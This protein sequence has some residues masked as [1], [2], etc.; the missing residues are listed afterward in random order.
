LQT[1]R[2]RSLIV[3]SALLGALASGAA[4]SNAQTINPRI[5]ELKY[6]N[7]FPTRETVDKLYNEMDF[8]NAVMAYRYATPLVAYNEFDVGLKQIGVYEGDIVLPQQFLEPNEVVLTG[9]NTTLYVQSFL[10]LAK[11]GPIVVEVPA[12]LY[13]AFFDLWQ[14]PIVAIGPAGDDK[15]K[16]GKFV[17]VPSDYTGTIPDGYFTIKS[18]TTLAGAFARAFVRDNDVAA[19]AKSLEGMRIYPLT[20]RDNPPKT[21]IVAASGSK[22]YTIAPQGFKYW[23]R[24]AD[25]LNR[26]S[27][28]DQ[29]GAFLQRC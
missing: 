5:G 25:V 1:I 29:D 13:G 9:N 22:F 24:V 8:Q 17:V 7:G 16:G 21:K 2:K 11:N 20:K 26:L 10:D 15:G 28:S 4:P 6:E 27:P 23:E 12:G 3:A 14:R 19:A 18:A